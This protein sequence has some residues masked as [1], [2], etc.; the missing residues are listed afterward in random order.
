MS[1][2]ASGLTAAGWTLPSR[3]TAGASTL[4]TVL[5]T[6]AMA[7]MGLSVNVRS[8]RQALRPIAVLLIVSALLSGLTLVTLL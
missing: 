4:T 5:L 7:G 3:A 1:L 6:V 2:L 8:L